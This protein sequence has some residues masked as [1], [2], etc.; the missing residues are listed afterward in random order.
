[1]YEVWR[2]RVRSLTLELVSHPSVTDTRGETRFGHL[3]AELIQASPYFRAHPNHVL[4]ARTTG[5]PIERY[6]LIALVRGSGRRAV[7]L[8]GHYDVVETSA[9]GD[10]EHLA[11]RP[12]ALREA[13]IRELKLSASTPAARRALADLESGFL[14]GR[15]VLDM[16]SGLAAGI[17]VLERF[18]A[19]PANGSLILI[20]T[21]DEENTSQGIRA[22][23][24]VLPS[25]IADWG[26]EIAG[27]INLD[28]SVDNGD[29][30][31]GRAVYTGSVGKLHGSVM[32]VGRP[33]HAGAPFDGVNANLMAAELTRR[34]ECDPDF[35]DPGGI[36]A[37]AG[38]APPP[39]VSLRQIDLKTS[40]N[41]TTPALA[42]CE[43][44]LLF[45]DRPVPALLADLK[46]A[47]REAVRSALTL[48]R[49]RGRLYATRAGVSPPA[50]EHQPR[51]LTV[52][53]LRDL[54]VMERGVG[55]LTRWQNE[56]DAAASDPALEAPALCRWA[57]E[58]LVAVAGLA[59]PAAVVGVA[60]LFYPPVSAGDSLRHQALVN[61]VSANVAALSAEIGERLAIRPHFPGISDMSFIGGRAGRGDWGVVL[62]NTPARGGRFEF[63]PAPVAQLDIPVVNIGPSGHDYHD[64][65]ERVH[66]E[67]SFAVVPELVW[68]V[69]NDLLA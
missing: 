49:Q 11:F 8:T 18:A 25:L 21:P 3:L 5:D 42:W 58:R 26:L 24:R 27:S 55:G 19:E 9:Y 63:D 62:E 51:V 46:R 39:P 20:A 38:D 17:A 37:A 14:P 53:E 69:V 35:N 22:A 64:R 23:M 10:L 44:N 57:T 50:L 31:R 15:G 30:T 40:Y 2:E 7:L 48:M 65:L 41:V 36:Q 43:I 32:F 54:V 45:H 61:V 13:L 12:E 56:V 29:G 66:E 1:M 59:G 68:R 4:L 34:I 52:A 60:N 6:S 16:K 28:A 47:A 67:Y 33:T